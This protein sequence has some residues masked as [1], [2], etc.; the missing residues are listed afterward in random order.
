MTAKSDPADAA[1]LA[2][3]IAQIRATQSP[4][5]SASVA[6]KDAPADASRKKEL[7]EV[8]EKMKGLL[9]DLADQTRQ[10]RCVSRLVVRA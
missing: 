1:D 4:L 10:P 8:S 7:R 9:D 2:A 5:D 6:Y 3:T